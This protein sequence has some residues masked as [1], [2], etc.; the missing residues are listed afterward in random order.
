MRQNRLKYLLMQRKDALATVFHKSISLV[1][2]I[3]IYA[4]GRCQ[5]RILSTNLVL[6]I[7]FYLSLVCLLVSICQKGEDG[8]VIRAGVSC[9]H[10]S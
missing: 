5:S 4:E 2:A 7:S 9:S 10:S 1:K 8:R 3:T 6:I